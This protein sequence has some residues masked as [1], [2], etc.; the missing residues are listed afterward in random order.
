MG[1]LTIHAYFMYAY[2]SKKR[3][4]RGSVNST[5]STCEE[6]IVAVPQGS[7]LGQFSIYF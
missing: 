5:V 3:S 2:L 7:I 1:F 4:Q 6:I